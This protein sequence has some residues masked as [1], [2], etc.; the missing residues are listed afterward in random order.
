MLGEVWR[1]EKTQELMQSDVAA[2]CLTQ[3][4]FVQRRA[5]RPDGFW[6]LR[7][8][9]TESKEWQDQRVLDSR[10]IQSSR[11]IQCQA[12]LL[13]EQHAGDLKLVCILPPV[14]LKC[15]V[16][17]GV[18]CI[19]DCGPRGVCPGDLSPAQPGCASHNL[20]CFF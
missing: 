3:R 18:A 4:A 19:Q 7:T 5:E 16:D 10:P 2:H 15:G 14:S 17:S 8:W 9:G 1:G 20:G 6:V 11:R 12:S 13:G